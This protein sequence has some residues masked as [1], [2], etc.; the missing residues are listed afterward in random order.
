L[1]IIYTKGKLVVR[2]PSNITLIEVQIASNLRTARFSS[3]L[4]YTVSEVRRV[5]VPCP[6]FAKEL[7][8]MR[9]SLLAIWS[10]T[11]IKIFD[12]IDETE[13]LRI[14]NLA[15]VNNQLSAI[16]FTVRKGYL[17]A[18]LHQGQIC[19]YAFDNSKHLI[20]ELEGHS[21]KVLDLRLIKA[22]SQVVSSSEDD[23]IRIFSLESMQ[24]LEM[25]R[26][27]HKFNMFRFVT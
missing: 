4:Y 21:K 6:S 3:S 20:N 7:R 13:I 19:V 26:V 25:F 12:V 23:T 2:Y 9:E 24:Q 22:D 16:C 10:V 27:G 17:V 5:N 8:V 1:D 14:G 15:S 11:D 18:G